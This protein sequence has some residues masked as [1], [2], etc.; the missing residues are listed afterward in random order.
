MPDNL[1]QNQ[2]KPQKKIIKNIPNNKQ[3]LTKKSDI[4]HVNNPITGTKKILA[5]SALPA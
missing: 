4:I 5:D 1:P 2:N 3:K